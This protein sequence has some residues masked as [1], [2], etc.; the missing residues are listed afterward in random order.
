[1][2]F[3]LN[4]EQELFRSFV[5]KYFNSIEQTKPARLYMEGN[6]ELFQAAWSKLAELG[7]MAINVPEHYDG[8]GFE[9]VSLVPVLEEVG[10]ALMPGV[11][12]ET[13][14]FAVPLLERF[15]TE[16]QKKHYL[17]KIAAG[18]LAVTLAWLE[19]D[20]LGYEE[21]AVQLKAVE[22]GRSFVLDGKKTL[23]PH[24]D[25]ADVLIVPVR[26]D[27]GGLT[28]LLV[29]RDEQISSRVQ[30]SVDETRRL[31][32]MTFHD[33][34]VPVQQV[35]GSINEGWHILQDGLH[36]LN[37]ALSATMVGGMD[38]VIDMAVEYAN[39][40][41]QFGQPIGRF[42]AIKHKLAD[43]KVELETARSLTYYAH[44]AL[45]EDAADKAAAAAS[46]RAYA[47]EAF[48]RTAGHNIQ[49]HGGIGF[50]TEIDCHLYLK[51]S[52]SLESYL[53]RMETHYEQ[54]AQ[55]LGW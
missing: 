20:T 27:N 32:E 22:Q 50:T 1:M 23:V 48:I 21:G 3:A 46:A 52:R 40:R 16:E 14:G 19:P 2:D 36:Y 30:D 6:D 47:T 13:V 24:G 44:W 34:Q 49:I 25:T 41:E 54:I 17:P 26:T 5:R 35:L 33:V 51:R 4:Q 7:C 10:R 29:E 12:L 55:G 18:E 9:Q 39:T 28:L 42:Q 15:G 38:R 37:A 53:G 43:M 11:Y 31:A 45:D 8:A